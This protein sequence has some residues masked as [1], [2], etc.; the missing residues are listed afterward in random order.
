M[1]LDIGPWNQNVKSLCLCGLLNPYSWPFHEV[2]RIFGAPT[3]E[4]LLQ[5]VE[6]GLAGSVIGDMSHGVN[7]GHAPYLH[8]N[9]LRPLLQILFLLVSHGY[10]IIKIKKNS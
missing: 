4:D 3:A 6:G 1:P 5:A 8:C 10:I 9:L 2:S 7:Y